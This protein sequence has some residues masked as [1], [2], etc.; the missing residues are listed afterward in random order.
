MDL[1]GPEV[2]FHSGFIAMRYVR[3][4]RIYYK[5]ARNGNAG[6]QQFY[7]SKKN[8]PPEGLD[9]MMTISRV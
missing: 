9:L 6:I 7:S 3:V 8:L 4:F 1:T 5:L 2:N